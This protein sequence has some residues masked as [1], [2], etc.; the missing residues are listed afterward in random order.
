MARQAIDHNE[1]EEAKPRLA[2]LVE[3]LKRWHEGSNL[4]EGKGGAPIVAAS[5]PAGVLVAS[6]DNVAIGAQS[7]ID[8]VSAADTELSAGR[9]IFVRAA[10]SLSLFAYSLGM[11]LVAGR[12][13]LVLQTHEGHIEIKSS[14]RI[15][16]IAAEGI[17]LQAPHVKVV[18]EGAQTEWRGG[19]ITQQS[20]GEQVVKATRVVH[21]GPGGA[22]PT[23]L[24]LANG[25]LV[26]DERF[27]V[28]DR[29]T[30]KPAKGQRY[31]ARHQ[32]GTTIEGV[33][34]DEGFTAVLQTYAL[35]DAEIRLLADEDEASASAGAA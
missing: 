27:L 9:N 7:K 32:D 33:T 34:D 19:V 23:G 24:D 11:K 28:I 20:S 25:D 13:N 17:D 29:Q 35:G 2:E 16:L 15:S 22:T 8:L 5:G 1:D 3:K 18:S 26:A 6:E 10:R 4:A 31:V 21:G 14:G 30:G 12:G